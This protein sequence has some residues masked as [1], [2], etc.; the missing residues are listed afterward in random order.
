MCATQIST[1][2]LYPV[3]SIPVMLRNLQKSVLAVLAVV[4]VSFGEL[5]LIYHMYKNKGCCSYILPRSL[6]FF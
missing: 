4:G 2:I 3:G 5:L 6:M 1:T